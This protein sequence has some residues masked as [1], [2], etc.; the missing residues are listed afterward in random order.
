MF[1][2][3]ALEDTRIETWY[4]SQ[5]KHKNNYIFEI[6]EFRYAKDGKLFKIEGYLNPRAVY[7]GEGRY[8]VYFFPTAR[9]CANSA[10]LAAIRN[11]RRE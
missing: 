8:R 10:Y 5:S 3:M 7:N 11:L 2:V 1:A 4:K 9:P 6:R